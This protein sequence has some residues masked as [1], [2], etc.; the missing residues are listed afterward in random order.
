MSIRVIAPEL[1]TV[2]Q[3]WARLRDEY[4]RELRTCKDVDR[5]SEIKRLLREEFDKWLETL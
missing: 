1:E 2:S 4:I 3:R 5:R